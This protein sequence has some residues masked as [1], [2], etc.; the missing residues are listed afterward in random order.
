MI[1]EE[2]PD[3]G[4]IP[5]QYYANEKVRSGRMVF[6]V[7]AV[8]KLTTYID[9]TKK[10]PPF[11]KK[12]II[13]RDNMSCCY[14]QKRLEYDQVTFDH[15]IS[16]AEWKRLRLKGNVTCWENI[17]S[18]CRSCN[19]LKGDLPLEKSGLRL[20]KP[21]KCP[22]NNIYVAG[23]WPFSPYVPEEWKT[24]LRLVYSHI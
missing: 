1:N 15:V 21:P 7:P 20:I 14:C 9:R 8:V 5:I 18:A 17:V 13:I 6:D 24:H 12:N 2:I 3:Q 10:R 22:P 4:M 19:T 11:S 23:F 16:R